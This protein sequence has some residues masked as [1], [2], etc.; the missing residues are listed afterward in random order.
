MSSSIPR[1]TLVAVTYAAAREAG[2]SDH[3]TARLIASVRAMKRVALNASEI[4]GAECPLKAAGL[5]G[6]CGEDVT[7]FWREFDSMMFDR[8]YRDRRA[9]DVA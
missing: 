2:M 5:W 3:R 1:E 6:A 8:G 7:A 9:Y 4:G